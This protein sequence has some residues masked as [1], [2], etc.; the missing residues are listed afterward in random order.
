[1]VRALEYVRATDTAEAV[2]LVAGDPTAAFLAGGTTQLDLMKD[3]VL[4]P[5]RLV[6]ITR[7]PLRAMEREGDVL[8][9]G[10]LVTMEEL[11]AHPAV[12][13]RIPLV[14][15]A[16]LAGASTQLRNMATIGGNLLQ[17]T[18]CRYFRDPAV[19]RCNKRDPGSG[20]A[21]VHGT[22][23]MHAV[24]GVSER[25]IA[26]HA[27][28]LAVALVA[29][30]AVVHIQ[31]PAD[32][33]RVPLT[34]FYLPASDGPEAETVLRRG[35][36]ITAV[37]VPL[38][39]NGAGSGYLKVRD[40]RSYEFALASAAVSLVLSGG[41]IQEARIGLGGVGSV[42][43][44]SWEAERELAGASAS[45]ENFRRAAVSAVRSAWTVPGTAFKVE[46]AQ[47]ALVR[48]LRTVAGAAS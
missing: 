20:C 46:L 36:L 28:D 31:G 18:R 44:R 32:R 4:D 13:E 38:L 8:R 1:M 29:L 40:R 3:G 35:E 21:A 33:R 27:S 17:R 23:R 19:A 37:D 41:A 16:L 5:A 2:G 39:P 45:V 9:V 42:P 25:C 11:A 48:A 6:D 10:A 43:W 24:L 47:R 14:R 22:A 30:D 15:E 26:A 7:L 12:V 34:E